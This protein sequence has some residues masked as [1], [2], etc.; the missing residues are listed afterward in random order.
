VLGWGGY[1]GWDPVENASLMPWLTG[2]AFLHSVMMQEKRGMMKSW[3][4]WLIFSTFLLAILGTL[5]TR[6][7][8]VSSVHAFAQSAIGTWFWVFLVITLAVCTFTFILQRDH[9][10]AEHHLES[11]VSRES[12]FAFNN[13]V[14]LVA[15]FTILWGTLFPVLSEYVQ[16]YR[17]TVSA[18]W[19]NRIGV[20]VGVFLLFLTGIG[21]LLAW[22]STSMRSIRRNFVIPGIAA[23][24]VAIVSIPLG[25]HP[26]TI[27]TTSE[28]GAFYAWIT[29]ALAAFVITAIFA[30]FFRG[31]RVIQR[32]TGQNLLASVIQ[33]TRRNT[34]RYGG[35]IVHFGV[36]LIF[37]GF[38]GQAFNT[39]KQMTMNYKQSMFLGPYRIEC[40][41][42]S[43]DTNANY[44][45]TFAMLN[46]YDR[47]GKLVTK[48]AP[49][50]RFYQAS[51]QPQTMVSNYSTPAWDLYV[52]FAGTD[53]STGQPVI[54]AFLNPLVMWIWIGLVITVLG[55]LVALVPNLSAALAAQKS[56]VTV[57]VTEEAV[58][59]GKAGD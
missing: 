23:L 56:R 22:R 51:Q 33:L 10:K 12:S 42:F 2:T 11:L 41:D 30:E 52:I 53:P 58:A 48:L 8:L 3:N 28:Q 20:P 5:L 49:E 50:L 21:P 43:Q 39:S 54:K 35:Y 16:G 4:A 15:C 6:S 14:L 55:T 34:R 36:V 40:E 32:H 7:G 46:V 47:G 18:P 24:I 27:F 31:A 19:Y 44:D 26:W 37:I 13:L 25:V 38:A 29:F 59:A 45:T 1:W 57:T 9:L 17:V